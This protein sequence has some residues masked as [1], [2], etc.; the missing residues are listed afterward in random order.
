MNNI[1]SPE[2]KRAQSAVLASE[3]RRE[4]DSNSL[5][6]FALDF[7]EITVIVLHSLTLSLPGLSLLT[8]TGSGIATLDLFRRRG[9]AVASGAVIM[10]LIVSFSQSC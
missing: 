2:I 7:L 4:N 10:A 8:E 3:T 1:Q 9:M 6:W 5:K